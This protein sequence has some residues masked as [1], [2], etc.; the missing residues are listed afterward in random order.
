MMAELHEAALM[1]A[2][3]RL[4]LKA[5]PQSTQVVAPSMDDDKVKRLV[6]GNV[7][8]WTAVGNSDYDSLKDQVRR[9]ESQAQQYRS[10][11]RAQID[12]MFTLQQRM[13]QIEAADSPAAKDVEPRLASILRRPEVQTVMLRRFIDGTDI[14]EPLRRADGTRI[15]DSVTF[16][17]LYVFT[18]YMTTKLLN[19]GTI[20]RLGQFCIQLSLVRPTVTIHRLTPR[21]EVIRGEDYPHSDFTHPH[22]DADG[23]PCFGNID[24]DIARMLSDGAWDTCIFY[25]LDYLPEV[26]EEDAYGQY[27]TTWRIAENSPV[28]SY[29][30][31]PAPC[32]DCG[33]VMD[34]CECN[35]CGQCGNRESACSCSFCDVCGENEDAGD[36]GCIFCPFC[37]ERML[38][39]GMWSYCTNDSHGGYNCPVCG[40]QESPESFMMEDLCRHAVAGYVGS[41]SH[42]L[43]RLLGNEGYEDWANYTDLGD[44]LT[45]E[46]IAAMSEQFRQHLLVV[47]R[48][49]HL[50]RGE[51]CPP[52]QVLTA[53]NDGPT[54][55]ILMQTAPHERE[56]WGQLRS[57]LLELATN[58]AFEVNE[59]LIVGF[60]IL[61]GDGPSN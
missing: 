10:A 7:D 54:N 46:T 4:E 18:N 13:K 25:V 59:G 23:L 37:D 40:P 27:Y 31:A 9:A 6:E 20:R 39:T 53:A 14:V 17:A 57:M 44:G 32:G 11:L 36:C 29:A 49:N 8:S 43:M 16:P 51:P 33:Y 1:E 19:D 2:Q 30:L 22:V 38:N 15:R 48:D 24:G 58:A 28:L 56:S 47:Q 5:F 35:R 3:V 26:H 41:Q 21:A 34:E 61:V 45:G 50:H 55:T 60:N 52:C 12:T 42:V